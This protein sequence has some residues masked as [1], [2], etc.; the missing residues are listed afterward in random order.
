M[1][2]SQKK[3]KIKHLSIHTYPQPLQEVANEL[4]LQVSIKVKVGNI[5]AVIHLT[6]NLL[7]HDWK[8]NKL[9]TIGSSLVL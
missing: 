8:K 6:V 7:N 4:V 2:A 5:L 3:K 1:V 9:N